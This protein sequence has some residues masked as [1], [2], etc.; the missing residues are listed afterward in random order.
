MIG[1]I[2]TYFT[3][4]KI[5]VYN[6]HRQ[7]LPIIDHEENRSKFLFINIA[8]V[9][10]W[11]PF[12]ANNKLKYSV[13]HFLLEIL[14]P[15]YIIDINW[16]SRRQALYRTWSKK[17]SRSKF[18]VIQHGSYVGGVVTDIAHRYISCD[19]FL[20]WGPYFERLFKKYNSNKKCEITTFGNP[21]YNQYN[22][23][24]MSYKNSRVQRIL[25]APSAMKQERLTEFYDFIQ[26]LQKLGFEVAYKEHNMQSS[27]YG[28]VTGVEKEMKR[29]M[30]I[31]E[32][33]IYDVIITDHSSFLLDAIHFKNP[34]IFFAP[35]DIHNSVYQQNKYSEHLTNACPLTELKSKEEIYHL[36][37][38]KKQEELYANLICSGTN[39]ISSL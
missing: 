31:L 14:Q 34:V 39:I 32:R 7:T 35:A 16:I 25:F 38:L 33:Q 10:G 23:V 5:I 12:K 19:V 30:D 6:K 29:T 27:M 3:N 13:M 8:P 15:Q 11:I 37:D 1:T 17:K 21:V 4:K 24:K 20:T 22:R 18:V 28:P 2:L 36:I 9:W 26:V